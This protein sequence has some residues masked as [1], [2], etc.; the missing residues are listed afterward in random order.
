MKLSRAVLVVLQL[1]VLAIIALTLSMC[2]AQPVDIKYGVDKCDWCDNVIDDQ[3]FAS[4]L[5]AQGETFKFNS[6]ECLM[7]FHIQP[8]IEREKFQASYVC[9]HNNPG[10]LMRAG[11][12]RFVHSAEVPTPNGLG[13]FAFASD[14]AAQT[15]MGE[16]SGETMEWDE[17]KAIVNKAW[18][19]QPADTTMLDSATVDTTGL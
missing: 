11:E 19:A 10:H 5:V 15:F 13:L 18:F 4:S 2:S 17:V 7:A 6:I 16:S 14:A 3:H 1:S 12:A 8:T 9:D